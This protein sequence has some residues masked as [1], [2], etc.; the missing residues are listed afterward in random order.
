LAGHT[1]A[2]EEDATWGV[3]HDSDDNPVITHNSGGRMTRGQAEDAIKKGF[4]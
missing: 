2:T 3:G 4:Y 1:D